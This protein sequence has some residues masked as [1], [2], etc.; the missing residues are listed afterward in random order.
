[1]ATISPPRTLANAISI[2]ILLAI[3]SPSPKVQTTEL[4]NSYKSPTFDAN[5][6]FPGFFAWLIMQKG[7]LNRLLY[8]VLFYPPNWS[9]HSTWHFTL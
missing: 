7:A 1:M 8:A 9:R 4:S 5:A 6:G 2:V 3:P